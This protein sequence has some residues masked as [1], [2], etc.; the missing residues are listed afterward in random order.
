MTDLQRLTL[1]LA[2]L[3]GIVDY[4]EYKRIFCVRQTFENEDRDHRFALQAGDSA[5]AE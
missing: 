1:R 5:E 3:Y 4:E 2:Y